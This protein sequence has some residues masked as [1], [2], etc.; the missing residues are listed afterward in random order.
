MIFVDDDPDLRRATSQVLKL[1]GF[2]V[3]AFDGAEA[4][5]AAIART[6]RAR[7]SPTSACRG[8]TA[9]SSSS[10][11]G[12][13]T[14]SCRCCWLPA[15]ATSSSRW[16]RSRT[17]P[18][19]SSPSRSTASGW[20][21]PWRTPP[22]SAGW[23]WRTAA[24]ARRR[25]SCRPDLPLIGDAPAIRRLRDTIRQVADADVDVLVLGETGTG[26]EVVAQLLHELEPRGAQEPRR[27]EL[28]RAARDRA[29]ERALRPRGRR[30]HRRRPQARRPLRA[31]ER[32]HAVPRRDRAAAGDPGQAAAGARDPRGRAARQQ[33]AAELDVRVV[34][35]TNVDL[36]ARRRAA[37]SARTST[38]G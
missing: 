24:C 32:R 1:A 21:P 35:A 10:G 2:E 31:C 23:C 15:T 12:R 22:R 28:R 17:A 9:S 18:T 37:A 14:R 20:R 26:K 19:T 38:T 36:G 25:P 6:S 27:A 13:S 29:R 16:R 7:W 5:L 11:S 33:R 8:S 3:R 30:L 4:A 34:A